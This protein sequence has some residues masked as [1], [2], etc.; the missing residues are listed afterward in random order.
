M[1]EWIDRQMDID[2]YVW[3]WVDKQGNGGGGQW[4]NCQVELSGFVLLYLDQRPMKQTN[5]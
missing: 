3:G 1:D 5:K 4:M 2:G